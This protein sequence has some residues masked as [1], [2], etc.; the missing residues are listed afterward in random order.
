MF[1]TES[2]NV[3]S[4]R[5]WEPVWLQKTKFNLLSTNPTKWPNTFKQFV[6]CYRRIVCVFL[7][8]LWDW[9][10]KDNVS[11]IPRKRY[12]IERQKNYYYNLENLRFKFERF[13]FG[14][15]EKL[16]NSRIFIKHPF[17]RIPPNERF[18]NSTLNK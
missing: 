1:Y 13:R 14:F 7:T 15:F 11:L 12:Q 2:A 4:I 6:D 9:P 3:F 8:I 5:F 17:Y 16:C 18:C 10:L